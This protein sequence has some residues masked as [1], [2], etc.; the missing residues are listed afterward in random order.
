[1]ATRMY[2]DIMQGR[3]PEG[4]GERESLELASQQMRRRMLAYRDGAKVFF[5]TVTGERGPCCDLTP[6]AWVSDDDVEA[7]FGTVLTHGAQRRLRLAG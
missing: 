4:M 7:R 6:T 1:M 3:T 2:A 5:G